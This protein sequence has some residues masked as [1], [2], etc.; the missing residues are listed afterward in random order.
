MAALSSCAPVC[1]LPKRK[2]T[3]KYAVPM[4]E[5]RH[6]AQLEVS[7]SEQ[8]HTHACER[9]HP[10]PHV[11]TLLPK[12]AH[13]PKCNGTYALP[14]YTDMSTRILQAC[15]DVGPPQPHVYTRMCGNTPA[16]TRAQPTANF[17]TQTL[18]PHHCSAE[19]FQPGLVFPCVRCCCRRV[20][21]LSLFASFGKRSCSSLAVRK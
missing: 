11:H 10:P 9:R 13:A 7:F 2:C 21:Y 15:T 16:F 19:D 20:F 12:H 5:C 8:A 14:K 17:P 4:A 18:A 6:I 3:S 1:A